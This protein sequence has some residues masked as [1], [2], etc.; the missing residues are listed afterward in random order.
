MTKAP[1]T[2]YEAALRVRMIT[3]SVLAHQLAIRAVEDA[4]RA[5]G[6]KVVNFSHREIAIMAN[7]YAVR[8]PELLNEAATLVER[9]RIE[10]H[11]GKRAMAMGSVPLLAPPLTAQAQS[12]RKGP[13]LRTLP[14]SEAHEHGEIQR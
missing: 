11:W 3:A 2:A 12:V 14:A 4:L 6:H 9:W 10:G 5:R 13:E 7:E 8:N 1:L